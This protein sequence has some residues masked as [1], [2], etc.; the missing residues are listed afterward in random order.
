MDSPIWVS[1]ESTQNRDRLLDNGTKQRF[2]QTVVET[3]RNQGRL[4][5]DQFSVDG[6]FLEACASQKS[7]RPKDPDNR[8]GDGSDSRG[9]KRSNDTHAPIV[10]PD[11]R[12]YK[13]AQVDASRLASIWG[14]C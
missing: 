13:K 12:L 2:F 6:T 14:T 1:T 7:F 10:D 11:C 5:E 4:S 8:Q 9:Q 3:A